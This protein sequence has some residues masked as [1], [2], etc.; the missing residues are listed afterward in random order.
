MGKCVNWFMQKVTPGMR[1]ATKRAYDTINT[2]EVAMSAVEKA[3]EVN[4]PVSVAYNQ[5]TQFE[6]FPQF[7][8]GVKEVSQQGDKLQHWRANIGGKEKEWDAEI[9]E[10][11]PDQVVAWRSTTG[12]PNNGRVRFEPLGATQT[13]VHLQME[14]EPEGVIENVG[15]ALGLVGARVE[16]D[17][18]RFKNF[19]ESRGSETGAWRGEIDGGQVTSSD[20]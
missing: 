10:Q 2:T 19:I 20:S 9:Y 6:Q 8:E 13:R 1:F 15:D 4:V 17:L 16:G 11:T 7:M 12:A 18:R 3:I 5:W 14:Y